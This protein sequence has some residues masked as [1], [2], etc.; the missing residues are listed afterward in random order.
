MSESNSR[1]SE[2]TVLPGA[3]QSIVTAP[4]GAGKARNLLPEEVRAVGQAIAEMEAEL[5]APILAADRV[6]LGL[7]SATMLARFRAWRLMSQR[8][9]T[10]GRKAVRGI[11]AEWRALVRQEIEILSKLKWRRD[12]KRVPALQDYLSGRQ[13]GPAARSRASKGG[14]PS[15]ES[16][17]PAP[18][19]PDAV[20]QPSPSGAGVPPSTSASLGTEGASVV[21]SAGPT[22]TLETPQ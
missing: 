9:M 19:R 16:P 8:G 21:S 7:L 12:L 20:S 3:W 15:I 10:D 5:E 6:M 22:Q 4:C 1:P 17:E 2:P 13:D 18:A 11:V 14:E